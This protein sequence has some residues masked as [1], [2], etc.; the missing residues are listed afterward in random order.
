MRSLLLV[1]FLLGS[2][3]VKARGDSLSNSDPHEKNYNSYISKGDSLFKLKNYLIAKFYYHVA[4]V[5]KQDEKYPSDKIK[6]CDKLVDEAEKESKQI[7]DRGDI[8]WKKRIQ[9]AR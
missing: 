5:L 7:E 2:C 8:C 9:F 4:L 1:T 3:L 6:L